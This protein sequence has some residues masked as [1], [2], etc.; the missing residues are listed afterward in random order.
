MTIGRRY[1]FFFLAL[2]FACFTFSFQSNIFGSAPSQFFLVH[3]LDSES[4]VIGR[5]VETRKNN[6]STYGGFLG[7]FQS[8]HLV[9]HQYELYLNGQ[10]P[11][12]EF[13][14][15]NRNF[16]IQ[17]YFYGWLES[18]YLFSG[19][20]SGDTRLYLHRLISS[21]L[22][23]FLLT[24]LIFFFWVNLGF[25]SA[26]SAAIFIVASQWVV[27]F[28]NNLYWMFFLILL[29]F[30]LVMAAYG[31][32]PNTK[33]D[34]SNRKFIIFNLLL[35]LAVLIKSLA[36]YEYISTIL[37]SIIV[38]S[39]LFAVKD[40]W[41]CKVFIVRA[42]TT[43]LSGFTG[44]LAAIS[45]HLLK[46]TNS[47][48][49][50]EQ[51]V[52]ILFA[53]IA[54]RTH[55]NPEHFHSVYRTSLESNAL[56]VVSLYFNQKLFELSSSNGFGASL[57]FGNAIIIIFVISSF[58]TLLTFK[59]PSLFGHKKL[60]LALV[61]ALWFSITAPL[62]WFILAKGHSFIHTHMNP[63]L[64]HIPFMILGYSYFGFTVATV[65]KALLITKMKDFFTDQFKAGRN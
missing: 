26:M 41:S 59:L 3:Q 51:S 13:R 61:C 11:E 45:F 5:L 12:S 55:G 38:P 49:D 47:T 60:N 16:G 18:I 54:K 56:D 30:T 15:Y 58:F 64:W 31:S 48:G 39:V 2:A 27:V 4:L 28:G 57:D 53:T 42:I 24:Y 65:F 34:L 1:Q 20:D 44:F 33:F 21:L 19:I 22:S 25:F 6:P 32:V 35:C 9:G 63:V 8:Q 23:A 14:N 62:S 29:P 50:L 7:R 37:V 52:Q 10:E 40:N 46:L 36:G 17:G 43:G